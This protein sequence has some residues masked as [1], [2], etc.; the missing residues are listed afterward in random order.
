MRYRHTS[1]VDGAG[2]I[3][4][5]GGYGFNTNDPDAG[6]NGYQNNVYAST[7]GGLQRGARL[8]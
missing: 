2:A 7:D 1:V 8:D 3:Y 4:V 6:S 5:I